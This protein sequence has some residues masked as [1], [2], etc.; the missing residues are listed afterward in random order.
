MCWTILIAVII[1]QV[2]TYVKK[3]KLYSLNAV[4][5]LP[6]SYIAIKL[7]EKIKLGNTIPNQLN[8]KYSMCDM[9]IVLSTL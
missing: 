2:Y 3:I 4:R 1:S 9:H 7:L 5:V 8:P 6:I